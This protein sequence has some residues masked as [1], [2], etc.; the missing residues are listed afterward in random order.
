MLWNDTQ[1]VN[2]LA[3][4]PVFTTLNDVRELE[5]NDSFYKYLT[6]CFLGLA[7]K[8]SNSHSQLHKQLSTNGY[9]YSPLKHRKQ[10]PSL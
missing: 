4:C 5:K 2:T 10:H 1:H 3:W 7:A 8:I 6:A 9:T